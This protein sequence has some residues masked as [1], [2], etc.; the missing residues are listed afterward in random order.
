MKV[1]VT[2]QVY[3]KPWQ[4]LCTLKSLMTHSE[5]WV[6]KIYL[7]EE[8]K[9]PFNDNIDLI[10]KYDFPIIHKKYKNW[11]NIYGTWA[12][13]V[14]KENIRHQWGIEKS[15]KKYVFIT[16]NDVLYTG[17]IIGNMLKEIGNNVAIGEIGQCWNCPAFNIC[18]GGEKWN[19]WNPSF[20]D[21][22]N[23]QLPHIRTRKEDLNK[24]FPKLMPECRVNEWAILVNRETCI[25]EGRPYFGEFVHDSGTEWFKTLYKK[26]YTF[27]DYRK[28]FVHCYWAGTGGHEVEQKEKLYWES[29]ELAKQYFKQNFE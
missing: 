11:V 9:H 2:I 25:K 19:N 10:F 5:Q 28:D 17:D 14:P 16:H 29:E 21:V 13:D 1:D 7:T 6:D 3:G 27:K 12:K 22:N 4:T 20:E 24:E 8:A 18:G 26:G 23:L 15:N